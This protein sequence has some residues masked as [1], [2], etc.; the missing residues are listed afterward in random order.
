MGGPSNAG[1]EDRRLTTTVRRP[2]RLD[3]VY[4][5]RC[6]PVTLGRRD[7]H[8]TR[9]EEILRGSGLSEQLLAGRGDPTRPDESH[10]YSS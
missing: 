3:C 1:E 9:W 5:R 10:F 8:P 4:H 7:P 2:Q 6:V